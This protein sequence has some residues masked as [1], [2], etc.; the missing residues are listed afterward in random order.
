MAKQHESLE[1]KARQRKQRKITGL[2]GGGGGVPGSAVKM[3][4]ADEAGEENRDDCK[5]D[6][7]SIC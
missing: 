1:Q 4:N 6:D 5:M 7:N 2:G 3:P